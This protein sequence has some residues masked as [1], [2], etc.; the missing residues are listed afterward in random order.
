MMWLFL[1]GFGHFFFS[2][3]PESWMTRSNEHVMTKNAALFASA[4]IVRYQRGNTSAQ[5]EN[6]P[7]DTV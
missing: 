5:G 6:T 4:S 7:G 3:S 1:L 2:A